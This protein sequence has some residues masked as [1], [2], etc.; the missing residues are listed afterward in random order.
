MVVHGGEVDRG[1][2]NRHCLLL[3]TYKTFVTIGRTHSYLDAFYEYRPPLADEILEGVVGG[4]MLVV[5]VLPYCVQDV[6]H[7]R[8]CASY[9]CNVLMI[10]V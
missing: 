4:K 1:W 10:S 8:Y 2:S 9:W 5:N 7:N 3:I 6:G